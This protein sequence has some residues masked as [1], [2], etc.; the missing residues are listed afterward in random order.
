VYDALLIVSFG[1][2]EG[3]DDVMPFLENVTKGREVPRQR[4][5]EVAAHYQ[6]FGGISPINAEVRRLITALEALLGREGPPLPVYWGNRNWHPMLAD[7]VARMADDGVAH[8][9]A[10]VTSAFSSYS[11]CRQYLEDLATARASVGPSA[12]VLEKLRVF[13][14]HPGFIDAVVSRAEAAASQLHDPHLVFTAHS[15]PLSMAAT[16]DYELQ[17]N[18]AS[19]LVAERVGGGRPWTLAYQ[20]R[21]GSPMQ[22]WLEPDISDHLDALAVQGV[23][24]VVIVPIGFVS[25]HMEVIYDLD[26]VAAERAAAAGLAIRRAATAGDHPSFVG[27]IRELAMERIAPSDVPP[28]SLGTLGPRL[29]ECEEGC[30]PP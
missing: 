29:G 18:E 25:D 13:F 3:P 2:P 12:P 24:S 9:L 22:P 5:L 16:S 27:M 30:C 28:R 10:F 20:S 7:T 26:V 8:A 21:S 1:G 17:L 11:G 4:L 15:I 23:T 19:R 6:R 14:N